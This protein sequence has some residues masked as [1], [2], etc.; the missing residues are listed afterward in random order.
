MQARQKKTSYPTP[1]ENPMHLVFS[2]ELEGA[3]AIFSP[4][5][6]L[7]TQFYRSSTSAHQYP[8][9]AALMC[10]VLEDAIQCFQR[11]FFSNSR[12]DQRVAREAEE[13]FFTNDY[14]HLFSFVNICAVLGL[15]QQYIRS[16]L[17][18]WRKRTS[19]RL[20]KSKCYADRT[21]QLS[22]IAA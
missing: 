3:N 16:R 15:D 10:A 13:W 8:G 12:R 4:E 22:Q 11:Q 6:I 17:K 19:A 2:N 18:R 21:H 5:V 14:E 9:V 20:R 1:T 7:P